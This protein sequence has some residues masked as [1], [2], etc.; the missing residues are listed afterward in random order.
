MDFEQSSNVIYQYTSD[1]LKLR[2]SLLKLTNEVIA[3]KKIFVHDSYVDYAAD[4]DDIEKYIPKENFSKSQFDPSIISR[5]INNEKRK[6]KERNSPNPYLIPPAYEELLLEQLQ[7]VN[8]I[9]LFWGTDLELNYIVKVFYNV[10]FGEIMRGE[11]S[12]LK[13]LLTLYV[14]DYVRFSRDKAFF[15][16]IREKCIEYWKTNF[17]E[18]NSQDETDNKYFELWNRVIHELKHNISYSLKQFQE[19]NPLLDSM[20][21]VVDFII[22]MIEKKQ[23][24]DFPETLFTLANLNSDWYFNESMGRIIYLNFE[25]LLQMYK[26]YFLNLPNFKFLN[27]KISIFVTDILTPYFKELLGNIEQFKLYSLG[28]RVKNIIETDIDSVFSH[29]TRIV[30]E[31]ITK[32][33]EQYIKLLETVLTYIKDV[34][35][36]Q[37]LLDREIASIPLK[38]D[39][40]RMYLDTINIKKL[41]Q[42]WET[43][44][45]EYIKNSELKEYGDYIEWE[46]YFDRMENTENF[47]EV[48]DI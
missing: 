46:D 14:S 38:E 29:L 36:M 13:E 39:I 15:K 6:I 43:N 42:E 30:S 28:Y 24:S 44:Y 20:Y 3:K 18:P 25:N 11:Q 48:E 19:G 27:K 22:N 35:G 12:E 5:I 23:S 31:S 40:E 32:L 10:L 1:R 45:I 16:L 7:F 2:K 33:D 34:E 17:P 8:K 47:N 41:K 9:E 4:K 21:E 37:W 26:D